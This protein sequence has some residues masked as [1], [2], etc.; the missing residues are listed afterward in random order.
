MKTLLHTHAHVRAAALIG[1]AALC[2]MAYAGVSPC[3]YQT[4]M[5]Q[6]W[7]SR[8]SPLEGEVQNA[9]NGWTFHRSDLQDSLLTGV[10]LGSL[11]STSWGAVDQPF[12]IPLVGPRYSPNEERNQCTAFRRTPSFEGLFFHPGYDQSID[13]MAVFQPQSTIFVSA[14]Q[15]RVELLGASSPDFLISAIF[16]PAVGAPVTLVSQRSVASLAPALTLNHIA[17]RLPRMMGPGDKI[18]IVGDSGTEP[19]EDWG[20]LNATITIDGAPTILVQPASSASCLRGEVTL[21]VAA[22]GAT[23]YQWRKNGEEIEGAV[24]ATYEFSDSLV[25]DGGIYDC[26]VTNECGTVLSEP[27]LVSVCPADFNCDGGIDGDDVSAFFLA[28]EN[29]EF[30][31]DVNGDGGVDGSDVSE[32]FVR[33]EAGSC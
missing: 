16:V 25:T 20:N 7:D 19:F 29:G 27:A 32:F 10:A 28:W 31:S 33:W 11:L 3:S 24:S 23:S 15:L 12:F 17:G 5:L 1:T 30:T 21:A 2:Q 6:A 18:M 26:M 9:K 13:V 8:S 22:A 14:L 4:S